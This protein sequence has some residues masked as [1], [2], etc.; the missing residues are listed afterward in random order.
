MLEELKSRTDAAGQDR[1]ALARE[2]L[3]AKED[4]RVKLY[5]TWQ[6]LT[7]RR[8]YRGLFSVGEYMPIE[9]TAH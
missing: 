3:G 2:L 5:V 7:C 8:E 9:V 1:S 4:G 6:A